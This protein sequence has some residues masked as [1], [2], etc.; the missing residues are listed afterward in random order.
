MRSKFA[1][2][3]L[4]CLSA[5]AT[6]AQFKASLQGT[7]MD[8]H[9]A[10]IA[11]AKIHILEQSTG[12]S[13]DTVTSDEGFYR[14]AQLPPGRYTVTVEFT[15]FKSSVSKDVEIKAEE[16]R[17]LDITL[18]V[19]TVTEQVTV[20]AS[21]EAL[22][23]ENANMGTTVSTEEISRLPQVGRDPYE[24]LRFTPGVFGDGSRQGNGQA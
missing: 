22:Q 15:G 12:L 14:V 4:L 11:G 17:G 13:R 8:S 24:L 21:A 20:S 1:L 16:P 18:E 5:V 23:T 7:V 2:L 10:A 19:G 6:Y 3:L 9:G